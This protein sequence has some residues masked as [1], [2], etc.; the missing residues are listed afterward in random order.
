MVAESRILHGRGVH[1]SPECQHEAR[2]R[3]NKRIK[4]TCP[5]CGV[6]FERSPAQVKSDHPTCSR[7]CH[8]KARALGLSKRIV[9]K[10]YNCKRKKPRRCVVCGSEFIYT[11]PSQWHCSRK[12]FEDHH[13]ERMRGDNNPSFI[14]GRSKDKGCYRGD[15]WERIRIEVYRR[16]HFR[17]RVCGKKC[18]K[19]EIQAHHIRRWRESKNNDLDNLVT[20]CNKC[21]AKV[22]VGI[23]PCPHNSVPS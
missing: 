7:D 2:R 8:Y 13:R 22:E 17:C 19:R 5:I 1:C 23:Y 12:C 6:E 18:G 15:D 9:T 11:K 10:P 16:D 21:H 3:S 14:D 20:L 4:F